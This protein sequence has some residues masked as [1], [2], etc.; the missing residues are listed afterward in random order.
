MPDPLEQAAEIRSNFNKKLAQIDANTDLTDD[1]KHRMAE[2]L[3]QRAEHGLQD[4]RV[5]E[6]EDEQAELDRLRRR[7]FGPR[8]DP[9]MMDADRQRRRNEWRSVLDR[10]DQL[11]TPE[12]ARDLLARC[13]DTQ[14]DLLGRA[15][16][17]RAA[18][19]NSPDWRA[20]LNDWMAGARDADRKPVEELLDAIARSN[21]KVRKVRRNIAMRGPDRPSMR[22][23]A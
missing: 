22:T 6:R 11:E 13:K 18:G 12:A 9:T 5:K 20:V 17:Y 1:A 3:W 14:D 23:S 21:D 8:F 7:A 16:A 2:E 10:A 19:S 4:V 15:I